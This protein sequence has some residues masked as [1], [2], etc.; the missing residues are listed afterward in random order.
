MK[1]AIIN[2]HVYDSQSG[3]FLQD[4]TILWSDGVIKEIGSHVEVPNDA[5]VIDGTGKFVTPGLI[6]AYTQLGL[7]ESGVR[8][9]GDDTHELSDSSQ[10]MLSVIDGIYPLDTSFEEARANGIT[11]V[12]VAP[13]PYNV[14]SGQTAIIKTAGSVIDEMI[15]R[16]RYGLAVSL[17]EQPKKLNRETLIYPLT[18]MGIAALLR[19]ELRKAKY[20]PEE[21]SDERTTL[22]QKVI[23]RKAPLFIRAY[24]TDDIMT[25][26]RL[27]EEFDIN[28]VLV[29]AIEGSNVKEQIV[30]A[31]VPVLAGPFFQDR[32]RFELK[33]LDP[34]TSVHLQQAG[35]SMALITDH[36]TSAIRN[37]SLEIALAVREG[38]SKKDAIDKVTLSAAKLLDLDETV[39]SIEVGKAADFALWDKEPFELTSRVSQTF[40]DGQAVYSREGG[41]K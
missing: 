25:A 19:S 23:Q 2:S 32:S 28:L 9:E 38:M 11:T 35:V 4:T 6:D 30:H 13:G 41:A 33:N 21:T 18:R 12:H 29:H 27:K 40:I 15:V 39:G 16:A 17:G 14:I 24:R 31:E 5:E 10:G 1:K 3:S 34:S 36:P 8:W 37:L 20:A 26:L 7:K 22:F